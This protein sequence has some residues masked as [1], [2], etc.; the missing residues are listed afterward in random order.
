MKVIVSPSG[1]GKSHFVRLWLTSIPFL[2]DGDDVKG[3]ALVY[4]YV[5]AKYGDYWWEDHAACAEKDSLMYPVIDQF[6]AHAPQETVVLSSEPG[7]LSLNRQTA[8]AMPTYET[9]TLYMTRRQ[10]KTLAGTEVRHCIKFGKQLISLRDWYAEQGR[11]HMMPVFIG[12]DAL[13]EAYWSLKNNENV[14][15]RDAA[16]KI[17]AE[18]AFN[19][20]LT[21]IAVK[22]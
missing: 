1:S 3:I 6:M 10:E 4:K 13:G 17:A 5:K 12:D 19:A 21:T 15:M 22:E 18:R 9:H 11:L 2:V 16:K 14:E 20:G 7:W 8:I